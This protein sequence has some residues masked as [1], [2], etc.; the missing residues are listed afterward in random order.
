MFVS[1][2]SLCELFSTYVT[3]V[4]YDHDTQCDDFEHKVQ[5]NWRFS[6]PKG[7]VVPSFCYCRS[8][9]PTSISRCPVG[10]WSRLQAL[11][12][13]SVLREEPQIYNGRSA[14][15]EE[16]EGMSTPAE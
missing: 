6:N 11:P 2:V 12:F 14:D 15:V 16:A 7:M 5:L 3:F 1:F 8:S 9:F 13:P 4:A 10:R